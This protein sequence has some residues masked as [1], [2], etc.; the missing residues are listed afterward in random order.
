VNSVQSLNDKC[1]SFVFLVNDSASLANPSSVTS[2]LPSM[3][4]LLRLFD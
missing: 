3:Y 4:K 1:A 2:V